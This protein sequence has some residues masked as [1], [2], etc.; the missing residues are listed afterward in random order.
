MGAEPALAT[1][2]D[3]PAAWPNMSK[4]PNAGGPYV[5]GAD[6]I[7]PVLVIEVGMEGGGAVE[8]CP[9]GATDVGAPAESRSALVMAAG[10]DS[11]GAVDGPNMLNTAIAGIEP[12]DATGSE[13]WAGA[14]KASETAGRPASG[15]ADAAVMFGGRGMGAETGGPATGG[16][17][18]G[19]ADGGPNIRKTGKASETARWPA[20]G[21]ADAAIV[22]GG[23][24]TA[25]EAGGPVTGGLADGVAD[26]GPNIWNTGA[27]CRMVGVDPWIAVFLPGALFSS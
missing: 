18:G 26:G 24:G 10:T 16:P 23:R 12:D 25:V 21:P 1:V 9:G 7:C 19:A 17:A 14:S 27:T 20:G 5:K 15:P 22:V 6:E 8:T 11:G 4:T 3:L 13:A 2:V